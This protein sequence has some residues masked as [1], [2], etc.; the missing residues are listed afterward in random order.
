MISLSPLTTTGKELIRVHWTVYVSLT[1]ICMASLLLYRYT[2][3]QPIGA[4]NSPAGTLINLV[5]SLYLMLLSGS[6]AFRAIRAPRSRRNWYRLKREDPEAAE[7]LAMF[8][9]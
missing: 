1:L 8:M 4:W 3:F 7:R 9:Q 6:F 5:V 2:L